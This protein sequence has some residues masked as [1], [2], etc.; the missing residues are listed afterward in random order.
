MVDIFNP[1]NSAFIITIVT[2][3]FLGAC[4]TKSIIVYK[5]KIHK[6]NVQLIKLYL[7]R[8]FITKLLSA[9]GDSDSAQ[10]VLETL[11]DDVKEYFQMDDAIIY[12]PDLEGT[13]PSPGVYHRSMIIEY[14]KDNSESITRSLKEEKIVIDTLC[15]KAFKAALYIMSL[16][17][18]GKSLIVFAQHN[19][20]A[21][22]DN[23]EIETLNNSIIGILSSAFKIKQCVSNT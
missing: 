11:I 3:L 12:S 13:L 15:N 5:E 1:S 9:L 19:G 20:R 10:D 17:R 2:L 4:L 21:T 23:Y 16:S 6:Q 7:D 22:L 14:M 18:D 8:K